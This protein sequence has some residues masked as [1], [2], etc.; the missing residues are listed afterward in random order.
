MCTPQVSRPSH[1][2][3]TRFPLAL[4]L[5][6]SLAPA[7]NQPAILNQTVRLSVRPFRHSP[8]LFVSQQKVT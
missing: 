1:R 3:V 2:A 6:V 5:T 7:C 8:S 4:S